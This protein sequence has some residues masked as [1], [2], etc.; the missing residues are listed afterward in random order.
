MSD[1]RE[2]V[3]GMRAQD[4]KRVRELGLRGSLA[5][6]ISEELN[7]PIEEVRAILNKGE[8]A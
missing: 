5:E 2:K 6:Q 3:F 4:K 8:M 1:I 7:L